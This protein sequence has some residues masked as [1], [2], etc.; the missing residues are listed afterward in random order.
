LTVLIIAGGIADFDKDEL[1][2]GASIVT[3]S[4]R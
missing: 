2:A 4:P 3:S 1:N